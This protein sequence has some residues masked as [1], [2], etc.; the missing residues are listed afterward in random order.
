MQFCGDVA[1]GNARAKECLEQHRDETGFSAGCKEELELMM[2]ARAAD[3]RLDPKLK[4]QCK[5]DIQRVCKPELG[6]IIEDL[7]DNHAEVIT[8]LQDFR[9]AL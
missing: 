4:K 2:A 6:D 5:K 7:P 9:F 8:C 1:P 3:F